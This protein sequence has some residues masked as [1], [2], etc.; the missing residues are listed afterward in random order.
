MKNSGVPGCSTDE[1]KLKSD[2]GNDPSAGTSAGTSL[3]A[4]GVPV[5]NVPSGSGKPS[6]KAES[7]ASPS[8]KAG[9]NDIILKK[10]GTN[11][12]RKILPASTGSADVLSGILSRMDTL[13]KSDQV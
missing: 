10:N 2:S 1:M 4:T 5:N 13:K 8:I 3:P 11:I 7:L 9:P 12:I 6:A